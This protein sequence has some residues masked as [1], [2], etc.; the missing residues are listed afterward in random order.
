MI[1]EL[2]GQHYFEQGGELIYVLDHNAAQG[3]MANPEELKDRGIVLKNM[4]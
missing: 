2:Y 4:T 1:Q 3:L